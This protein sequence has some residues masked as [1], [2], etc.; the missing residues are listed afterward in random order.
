M[1][2]N[3][4]KAKRKKKERKTSKQAHRPS[5]TAKLK[6]IN[7]IRASCFLSTDLDLPFSV[8]EQGQGG[9]HDSDEQTVGTVCQTDDVIHLFLAE[10]LLL[11]VGSN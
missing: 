5:T 11:C 1:S 4:T 6:E 9:R 7:K 8:T 2:S 10:P 3:E